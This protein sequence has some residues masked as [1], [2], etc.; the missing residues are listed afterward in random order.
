MIRLAVIS[1]V[2]SHASAIVLVAGGLAWLF[3]PDYAFS[4]LDLSFPP[5]AE[6]FG[7]LLGA[8]WLGFA[9]LNWIQRRAIL[10]GVYGRP[11]VMANRPPNYYALLEFLASAVA[12]GGGLVAAGL[13]GFRLLNSR[14][15]Q[16]E[17]QDAP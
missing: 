13:A 2:V 4:I 6:W 10:G 3:A 17:D 5:G 9:A 8:A 15:A 16:V 1:R 11:V 12:I 7:Q 14:P